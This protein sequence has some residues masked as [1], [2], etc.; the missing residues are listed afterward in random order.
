MRALVFAYHNVGVR[1]LKALLSAGVEVPL[2]VTHSDDPAETVWFER[3]IDVCHEYEIPY[4]T[5]ADPNS[6]EWIAQFEEL[7]PD[8]IFSFYYR[9]MLCQ[10]I[11]W[12]PLHGALNMHGSLLPKYRGR[13]P[14]NWAIIN[15]ETETGATLHYMEVKPDAGD[16][17]AQTAVPILA[18][19]TAKE[20]FDKVTV[21]AEIT[22]C[23]A[24]PHLLDN[25]HERTPLDLSEGSYFSGRQPEDGRIDWHS[26]PQEIH[27]LVRAVAPP[28]YPGAF[29]EVTLHGERQRIRLWKT[30][31]D[32]DPAP[33]FE[34]PTFYCDNNGLYLSNAEGTL[35]V[36]KA[37]IQHIDNEFDLNAD[38]TPENFTELLGNTQLTLT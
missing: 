3:V 34:K 37:D 25:T 17:V 14:V 1:C 20:V 13:A 30:A 26:T 22:L 15:G 19:D 7:A 16:I 36:L 5:P 9:K 6:A 28:Y 38:L 21:A 35:R 29:F 8:F 27:N 31:I 23:Q 10:D 2:V 11:L 18:D 32:L 24:L 33:R 12:I 4:I